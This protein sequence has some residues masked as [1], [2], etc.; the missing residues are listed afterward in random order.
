MSYW[1]IVFIVVVVGILVALSALLRLAI[2]ENALVIR[3]CDEAMALATMNAWA[4]D[5]A[6]QRIQEALRWMHL[7]RYRN[8][9]ETLAIA[10]GECDAIVRQDPVVWR[11]MPFAKVMAEVFPDEGRG[12]R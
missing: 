1:S 11:A 8:A 9:E 12:T 5:R 4:L 6:R 10:R 2:R 3:Q 7:V